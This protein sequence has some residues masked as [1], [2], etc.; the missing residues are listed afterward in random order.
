MDG[1]RNVLEGGAPVSD[2]VARKVLQLF[3]N[4]NASPVSKP[5]DFELTEKELMILQHLSK[6]LSY[7]MIAD[8]CAISIHTVNFHTKNIYEKLHVHSATAA[9]AKAVEQKIV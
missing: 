7:K 6:G 4:Q 9:I 1:I 8:V 3:K 2:S 5:A